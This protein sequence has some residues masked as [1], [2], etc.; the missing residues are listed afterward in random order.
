MGWMRYE[1]RMG[2]LCKLVLSFGFLSSFGLPLSPP[3]SL[4][5]S[6]S[7]SL[8]LSSC[9]MIELAQLFLPSS[10]RPKGLMDPRTRHLSPLRR[11]LH[12]HHGPGTALIQQSPL[13]NRQNLGGQNLTVS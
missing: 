12:L 9:P 8:C 10:F 5:L 4:S 11:P 6:L 13:F 3:P 2:Q 1:G 7:L